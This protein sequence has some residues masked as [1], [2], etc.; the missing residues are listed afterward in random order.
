MDKFNLTINKYKWA[1]RPNHNQKKRMKDLE[2]R[3]S[4]K[5]IQWLNL[6]QNLKLEKTMLSFHLRIRT[7][8]I[9]QIY[10]IPRQ[11]GNLTILVEGNI[12]WNNHILK[13]DQHLN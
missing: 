4:Y 12:Q 1:I 5:R 2:I 13:R 3:N 7:F 6:I 9:S 11:V 10:I 8:K